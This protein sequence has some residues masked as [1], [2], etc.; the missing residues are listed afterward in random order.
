MG[1]EVGYRVFPIVWRPCASPPLLDSGPASA[2]GA[3]FRRYGDSGGRTDHLAGPLA[4][5]WG[6]APALHFSDCA[7]WC[8]FRFG[9]PRLGKVALE[10]DWGV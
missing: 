5:G 4:P 6:Q 1:N 3:W 8:Q 9:K 10:V 2:Y 7:I